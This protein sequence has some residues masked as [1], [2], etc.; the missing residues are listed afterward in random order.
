MDSMSV[1]VNRVVLVAFHP[2]MLS[3]AQEMG[4]LKAVTKG[5]MDFTFMGVGVMHSTQLS[6]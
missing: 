2:F 1:I 5:Q 4:R 6:T 3:L